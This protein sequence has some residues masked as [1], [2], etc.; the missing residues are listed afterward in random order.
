[1]D[2]RGTPINS[3]SFIVEIHN[4]DWFRNKDDHLSSSDIF[5][6]RIEAHRQNPQKQPY[7]ADV[8]VSLPIR[9]RH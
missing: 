6:A 5:S 4:E 1:V 3:T 2:D 7:N 9:K 8:I